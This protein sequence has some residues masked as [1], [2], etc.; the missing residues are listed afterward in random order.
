[1]GSL[2]IV[3]SEKW[4]YEFVLPDGTITDCYLEERVRGVHKTREIALRN[5][6]NKKNIN[7]GRALD[8]ACHEGFYSLVL[9]DYFDTVKGIDKNDDSIGKANLIK[10]VYCKNCIEFESTSLEDLPSSVNFDFV[11]CYGLLYHVQN[12]IEII[13]S[14]SK[15]CSGHM[16]LETQVLPFQIS[17][18]VE[19]GNYLWQ[20]ET[21][22]MFG[23]FDDYPES[24]EGGLTRFALVPSRDALVYLLEAFGFVNISF[25]EPSSDDYE[26]F[27]RG[28]RVIV[29][30]EKYSEKVE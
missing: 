7:R 24:K 20:R 17:G 4:F 6:L 19:D 9:S 12:P 27:V 10:D 2:E 11:L 26:Q 25:Y 22:G 23:L 28:S 13:Q 16:C 18:K 14:I 30:A 1:L 3:K 5:Y 29:F 21:K 8:I 15:V